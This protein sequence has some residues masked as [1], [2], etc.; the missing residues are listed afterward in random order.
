M[1]P[2]PRT[3]R[4]A[5]A[6]VSALAACG[7]AGCRQTV[8]LDTAVALDGGGGATGAAGAAAV[9]DAG[10]EHGGTG[11]SSGSM[12]FD[13]GRPDAFAFCF[14][15]QI[16]NLLFQMRSPDV[17]I[18]I[19]RSSDMQTWFG[20]AT[21]LEVIQQEVEALITKYRVVKFG[22]Q[23]FPAT[24]GMCANGQG[25]CAGDVVPPSIN[26]SKPIHAAIH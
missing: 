13:G 2:R 11:G 26:A 14:G 22:Y 25:C 4:R 3:S 24:S 16:Q 21:R 7:L 9:S 5:R 20:T 10:P 23:E 18:S 19:D 6:L 12:R 17:I 15:G 1:S 8:M